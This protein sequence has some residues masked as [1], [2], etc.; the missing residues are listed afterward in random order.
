MNGVLSKIG[1]ISIVFLVLFLLKKLDDY[2]HDSDNENKNCKID[3]DDD[4][5]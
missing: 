3:K 4:E 2:C 1:L 5:V